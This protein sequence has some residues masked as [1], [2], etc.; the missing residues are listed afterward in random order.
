MTYKIVVT[1]DAISDIDNAINYYQEKVSKN[2]LNFEPKPFK[3]PV[4][5]LFA[6]HWIKT[7]E[8][9]KKGIRCLI[10]VPEQDRSR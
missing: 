1:P 10:S 6:T 4:S 9:F 7:L 2:K 3:K 8:K 5:E